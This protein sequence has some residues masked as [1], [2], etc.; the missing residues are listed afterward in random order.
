M[1]HKEHADHRACH[2]MARRV[3]L[4]AWASICHYHQ[5][6]LTVFQKPDGPV[7][8]ADRL[9][10]QVIVQSLERHFPRADYGY[11]S[12]E[13]E[14][15]PERF[16]KGRVWIIDPIDGTQDFIQG[17]DDFALHIGMVER[18]GEGVWLPVLGVVYHPR[19][20][21]MFGAIR[22]QGAWVE[23]E[24]RPTGDLYWWSGEGA[25]SSAALFGAPIRLRVSDRVHLPEL[26]AVV[27]RS[28]MT[29]RLRATLDGL[30]LKGHYR[31]G[32]LGV[33]LSEVA[34]GAADFYI[35]TERGRCKEWDTCAPH[36]ILTEAGGRITD[37]D[38]RDLT[39]NNEDVHIQG[40]VLATNGVC[41]DGVMMAL[42]GIPVLYE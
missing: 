35:L 28:H 7:T 14:R 18:D 2:D 20:G 4:D 3:A 10:D 25:D 32:S 38:G 24:I 6:E 33:K 23:E 27:S 16:E 15:D 39:Y 42:A 26:T 30:P 40:G 31:R 37:L 36:M 8:E 19:A 41:H 21:R 11:L 34:R 1:N 9:A 12:E 5:S 22:G 13:F 29:R 17:R